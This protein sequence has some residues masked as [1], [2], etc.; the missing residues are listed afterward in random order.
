MEAVLDLYVQPL[1]IQHPVVCVDE[2]PCQLLADTHPAQPMR[3]GVAKRLDHEYRRNGVA[4]LFV[5][6]QPLAGWRC[7]SV[8]ARRTR[9]DFALFLK[10]LADVHFPDAVCIHLVVD[11]LNIHTP[12]V[13]YDMFCPAEARRLTRRFQFHY[14]P[15]HASW[16]NMAEIELSV[17]A[18][19]LPAR[20]ASSEQLAWAA[21]HFQFC[22]NR[23]QMTIQ[24]RFSTE[25]AR[26][27]LAHLYPSYS[28]R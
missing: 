8:T 1:D 27:A 19:F 22:R 11:N 9:A 24:W 7:L 23:D 20:V 26:R 5:A 12:A 4:N 6:V 3:P 16:L 17:F 15:K 2:R 28:L 18:R 21:A 13:L 10:T 25:D 14:T